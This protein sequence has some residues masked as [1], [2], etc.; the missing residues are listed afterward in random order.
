[1]NV[2]IFRPMGIFVITSSQNAESGQY[3]ESRHTVLSLTAGRILTAIEGYA[4]D[5]VV[6]IEI[7]GERVSVHLPFKS[8]EG[9]RGLVQWDNWSL[10]LSLYSKWI[11]GLSLDQKEAM[12]G[13]VLSWESAVEESVHEENSNYVQAHEDETGSFDLEKLKAS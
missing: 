12:I 8:V 7:H 9:N 2:E 6:A 11:S 3:E 1:M 13:E 4:S 5:S 10:S